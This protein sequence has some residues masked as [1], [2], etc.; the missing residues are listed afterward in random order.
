MSSGRPRSGLLRTESGWVGRP[1]SDADDTAERRPGGA[2]DDGGR[3]GIPA[4]DGCGAI[5]NVGAWAPCGM[6]AWA[7]ICCCEHNV[8]QS[9]KHV[10]ITA[11]INSQEEQSIKHMN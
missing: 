5:G 2:P 1:M 9:I 8:S 6:P 10:V 7:C 11:F 3:P 4:K